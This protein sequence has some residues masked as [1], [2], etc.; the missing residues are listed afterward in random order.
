MIRRLFTLVFMGL[1]F[2]GGLKVE[3]GL[4][5]GRCTHAGG[6]MVDGVCIGARSE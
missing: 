6:A 2:Y 1:A 4:S 5:E 3:R